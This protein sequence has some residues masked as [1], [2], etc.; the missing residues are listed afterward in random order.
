MSQQAVHANLILSRLRLRV[1]DQEKDAETLSAR[2]DRAQQQLQAVTKV[3]MTRCC[4]RHCCAFILM[5][6]CS[7]S[8]M[9][10]D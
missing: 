3:N 9:P 5:Q 8:L 2:L 6:G 7:V 10:L 1:A 4:R